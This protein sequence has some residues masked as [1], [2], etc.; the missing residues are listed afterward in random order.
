MVKRLALKIFGRVQGVGLRYQAQTMDN[1][2][3]MTGCIKKRPDG[4]VEAAF[5]GT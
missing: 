2:L 3:G 5:E 4:S 1:S